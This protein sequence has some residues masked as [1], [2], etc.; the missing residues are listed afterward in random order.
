[1]RKGSTKHRDQGTKYNMIELINP[2][3]ALR[4]STSPENN[5]TLVPGF[6]SFFSDIPGPCNE[7]LAQVGDNGVSTHHLGAE[8]VAEDT[9]IVVEVDGQQ[10]SL[11][12]G[13]EK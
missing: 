10:L 11:W 4:T 6:V 12:G 5:Q 7:V 9:V 8:D 13:A 2:S 3:A 1:M